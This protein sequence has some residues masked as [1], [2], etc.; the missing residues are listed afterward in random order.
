MN[1][2]VFMCFLNVSGYDNITIAI[3]QIWDISN[4]HFAQYPGEEQYQHGYH[5]ILWAPWEQPES[6]WKRGTFVLAM[7][8]LKPPPVIWLAHTGVNNTVVRGMAG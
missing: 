4:I 8:L 6:P 1:T 3:V 7:G 2:K 5:C